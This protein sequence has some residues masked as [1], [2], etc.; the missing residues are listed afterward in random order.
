M[1]D[2]IIFLFSNFKFP[3][4]QNINADTKIKLIPKQIEVML[5]N[6]QMDGQTVP[7]QYTPQ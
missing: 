7:I 5:W 1:W 4:I 6:E 3:F 2:E